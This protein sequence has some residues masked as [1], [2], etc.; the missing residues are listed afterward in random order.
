MNR[1]MVAALCGAVMV[2]CGASGTDPMIVATDS[3]TGGGTDTGARADAGVV[4]DRGMAV[5]DRGAATDR[6]TPDAG[7]GEFGV[8]GQSLHMALCTCGMNASCQQNALNTALMGN[9][10]CATC[11]Q[12][13]LGG[14]CPDEIQAI[15]TC[16]QD[17]GCM[18]QACLTAMC[19]TQLRAADTCLQSAQMNNATCQMYFQRCLGESFP[20]LACP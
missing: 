18:D 15:Q 3:G 13:A 8:C 12:T 16:A 9:A 1:W 6:G 2:G 19:G 5:T 17:M 14:C 20:Q 4:T 11:Y 7:P 10:T